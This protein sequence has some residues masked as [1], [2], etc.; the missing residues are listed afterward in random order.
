[1]NW[2]NVQDMPIPHY[3]N[4]RDDEVEDIL[5]YN[6][7]DV[8]STHAFYIKSKEQIQM[9]IALSKEYKLSLINANAPKIGAEIFASI[10]SEE[11]GIPTSEL[12]QMRTKRE[13]IDFSELIFPYIKFQSKEFTALLEFLKGCR[14]EGSVLKGFFSDIKLNKVP[15][16][17]PYFNNNLVDKK[18]KTVDNLHIIYRGFQYDYGVGGIHG[19]ISAGVY[20]SCDK[21]MIIDI[22]VSSFYPNLAIRNRFY[23]LHLGIKFCDIYESVY[24]KRSIA[25]KKYKI[26]K[27]DLSA[28]A[29]NE[30][31]KLALNGSYGKSNEETSFF[32]D[33]AYTVATT[34]NGQL[35]LTMLAEEIVLNTDSTL[36]QVNTDGLTVKINRDDYDKLKDICSKWEQLTSLELEYAYYKKMV[37]RDVNNYIGVYDDSKS[38]PK[39]KGDFEINKDWHKDHSM[40]I[41][42]KA[43]EAYYVH[44][45]PIEETIMKS[46]DIYDFTLSM[47]VTR[48]WTAIN[49]RLINGEYIEDKLQKNNRYLITNRGGTL[50]KIHADGREFNVEKSFNITV[51]NQYYACEEFSC[52]DINYNYYIREAYKIINVISN[53][54]QLNLF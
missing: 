54:N 19:C 44:G 6:L 25:K 24:D 31:L 15:N 51:F 7:N 45:I 18:I 12:K 8:M 23:P 40:K 2:S 33:P 28:F 29:V 37:I 35:L 38:K 43:L 9:R 20:D 52:Y 36:L 30:G 11:M 10:I 4:V 27:S 13:Y 48:G 26:D 17:L 3:H 22:D 32:Y 41:V 47:K 34:V 42:P 53:N 21:Y 46:T 5:K 50:M 16:L 39:L 1:M 14:I 49:R